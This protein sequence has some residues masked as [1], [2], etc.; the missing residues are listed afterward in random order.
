VRSSTRTRRGTGIAAAAVLAVAGLGAPAPAGASPQERPAACA[1]VPAAGTATARSLRPADGPSYTPEQLR[2]IDRR[3]TRRLE[4]RGAERAGAARNDGRV[5][6][7]LRIGVHVH[8]VGG[9]GTKGASK[10]RVRRQLQVINAAY[11]GGQGVTNTSTRFAFYLESFDRTRKDRWHHARI[12]G[13]DD[14]EM[15]HALHRG[16]PE[17]LNLYLLEPRDPFAQAVVLGWATPPTEARRQPGLD[18][19]VIH[20]ESLPGGTFSGYNRGD[21]AVHE[22]GHWLGLF[23]TFEG[24]CDGPG[25]LVADT[26]A[27]AVASSA[28]DPAKDSCT[29]QPGLDPIN[30]FMDYAVDDC[31]NMFTPGQVSRM[32]DNW[33]AYRTP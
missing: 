27:Q 24:G 26:P 3:L 22:I 16:G 23:H 17:D 25:D 9:D 10:K 19:V 6:A 11:A 4:A 18:G 31:M 32:H 13:Q 7:T 2:R 21:T 1:S 30:N 20:Q 12:G 15:R 14:L 28:C 5:G 29:V 33:L 8:V